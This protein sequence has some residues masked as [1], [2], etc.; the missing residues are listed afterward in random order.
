MLLFLLVGSQEARSSP[1]HNSTPRHAQTS[2]CAVASYFCWDPPVQLPVTGCAWCSLVCLEEQLHQAQVSDHTLA[3]TKQPAHT[4]VQQ[5]HPTH[6][7]TPRHLLQY[8]N[9]MPQRA[10]A[11]REI[12]PSEITLATGGFH[13][14]AEVGEGGFGKVYRAMLSH[15]PVA[16]KVRLQHHS[17][18]CCCCCSLN[19]SPTR[20]LQQQQQQAK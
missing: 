15:Q 2:S 20:I 4:A 12:S 10:A 13:S 14:L 5:T 8:P 11:P 9:R 17:C 19:R 6:T 18:C 7:R 16:I 3:T 1:V